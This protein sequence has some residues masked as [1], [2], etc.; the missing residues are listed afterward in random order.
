MKPAEIQV[1]KDLVDVELPK[2]EQAE[3]SRLPPQYAGIVSLV[4]A[5]LGPKIQAAL[6]AKVAAIPVDPA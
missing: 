4:V 2:I 1:L 5:A 6:D 3:I